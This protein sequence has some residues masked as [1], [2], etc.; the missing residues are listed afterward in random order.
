[1]FWELERIADGGGVYDAARGGFVSYAKL[2]EE[3]ARLER[4]ML[5][6]PKSLVMLLC[7]NGIASLIGYIA[8]LR[9]GHAVLLSG[10][11]ADFSLQDGLVA[12]YRPQFLLTADPRRR[13]YPGYIAQ[14]SS[15]DDLGLHVARAPDDSPIHPDTAVLLSTSG[16]TG[17]PKA[18]RLSYGN[19]QS[20]AKSI[21]QYLGIDRS[22]TAMTTLPTSYSY[23]LSVIN[24]HLLA[25]AN[26]VCTNASVLTSDF[27]RLFKE[28][29][30]S[31]FAG[32]PTS[33]AM[34]ERLRFDRMD[35]PALRTLTQAGGR[36]APENTRRFEEFARR[37]G[38]A[39]FVMYGQ[40]E[41]SPRIAYVPPARLAEKIG[42]IGI[43]VPGGQLSVEMT[44]RAQEGELVYRGPNVMMGYATGRDGLAAGDEMHGCLRTGDIGYRD[45]D[46]YFYVTGR[47]K[48]FV[49]VAG[50]RMNLDDIEK[51]LESALARPVACVGTDDVL[52]VVVESDQE[53]VTGE[54]RRRVATL[55]GLHPSV[56]RAYRTPALPAN[57][58]GKKDYAAIDRLFR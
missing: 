28:R 31:S 52:R 36:L 33:Y 20:N 6:T 13:S 58:Y 51:M 3:V 56:V 43:P 57:A 42:S 2:L 30:C 16:T 1:M 18:V 37:K 47:L 48:R 9:S 39:M 32:V 41:A 5:R 34:L 45:P 10:A 53:T 22:D 29:Q 23:G 50:L 24:S 40:T 44:D 25:G 14:E 12:A 4:R 21:V 35:L 27:W 15:V 26:L 8:A 19:V 55:Y 17:S 7:D 38:I 49:K 54:A 46:G 11:A